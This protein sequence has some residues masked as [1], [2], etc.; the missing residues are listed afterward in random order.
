MIN[1]YF[2]QKLK[3]KNPSWWVCIL[4]LSSSLCLCIFAT[5]N[6]AQCQVS[7][8]GTTNTQVTFGNNTFTIV[9]G[10]LAGSNLFH[11]FQE[12]SLPTGQEAFFNNSPEITNIVSRVTGGNI[13]NIDGL[14]RAQGE[15][16]LFLIN[17]QGIIF[18]PN[19][20]LNLGGSFI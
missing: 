2:Y 1:N 4:G 13:S 15:A 8:D 19:A 18:G 6:P 14:I 7:S 12:F 10:T 9:G 3:L 17:P 5:S 16:N 20:Q 11:S